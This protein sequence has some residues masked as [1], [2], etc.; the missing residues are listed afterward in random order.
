[1][2]RPTVLLPL[3]SQTGNCF[4]L[5]GLRTMAPELVNVAMPMARANPF[6]PLGCF[7]LCGLRT[8]ATVLL[9]LAPVRQ[10]L[11]QTMRAPHNGSSAGE[12]WQCMPLSEPRGH[13]AEPLGATG[14]T[15]R[16]ATG[17]KGHACVFPLYGFQKTLENIKI[18]KSL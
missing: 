2:A 9:P 17:R 11:F 4:E 12:W 15:G 18:Y 13:W 16:K 1:M 5:C 10:L 14:A 7:R 3:A 8:M 6:L